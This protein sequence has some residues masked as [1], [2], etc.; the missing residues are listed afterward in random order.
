MNEVS[1]EVYIS[2]EIL[3]FF[4]LVGKGRFFIATTLSG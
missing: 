3:H 1:Q 2:K 4:L